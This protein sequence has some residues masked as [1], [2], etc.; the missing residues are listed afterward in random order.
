MPLW[1]VQASIPQMTP[2]HLLPP[3]FVNWTLVQRE[4]QHKPDKVP[5]GPDGRAIDHTDPANWMSYDQAVAVGLPV[6][7]VLT[8]NDPFVFIDLD[9]CRDP[10]SGAWTPEAQQILSMFPGALMEIS[11]SGRG[12]HII[13]T[14]EQRVMEGKRKKWEGDKEVYAWGRFVALTGYGLQGDPRVDLTAPLSVW[15]PNKPD[16]ATYGIPETGPVPE[17]SGETDDLALV[18]HALSARGG[19]GVQF[20]QHAS[21]RD[22]WTGNVASLARFYPSYNQVDPFD[23][24]AADAALVMHLGF[25]TGKDMARTERLWRA[26]PLTQG[27]RKL[28]RADYVHQTIM[29]GLQKVRNVYQRPTASSAALRSAIAGRLVAVGTHHD[30]A[31]AYVGTHRERFLYNS[32]RAVWLEWSGQRW[33][34]LPDGAVLSDIRQFCS[35]TSGGQDRRTLSLGFWQAVEVTCQIDPAFAKS[36]DQFDRDNYLLNTP[37]G[38]IDLRTGDRHAHDPAD[39]ITAMTAADP[40][41]GAGTVWARFLS[42]V[43]CGDANLARDLQVALGASLSGAVEDH[44]F[45]Y[46]TGSGRNGKSALVEAVAHALGDYARAVPAET[47]VA[48]RNDPHPTGLTT[49]VG[50]RLAYAN[51]VPAGRYFNE[52]LLKSVTGDR[53]I[54]ARY[55]RGDYFSFDRTFKLFLIGNDLPQ[56]RASDVAMQRR[57]RIFCLNADFSGRE[58]PTLPDRLRDDAG[59]ILQWLIEGHRLWFTAG[60]SFKPSAAVSAVSADYFAAQSTPDMW[61]SE[62][63]EIV[64]DDG[65]S[66]TGWPSSRDAYLN[67]RAW[68]SGR[69]EEPISET[70]FGL[71]LRGKAGVSIVKA[72]AMRC[73]GLTLKI[74]QIPGILSFKPRI[75]PEAGG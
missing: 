9:N 39:M 24:S 15:V 17:W 52:T 49:L 45:G 14:C 29:T 51:E 64:P 36:H 46:V 55:M 50:A 60:R 25:W 6:A 37:S 27:R 2:F 41:T 61:L 5:V 70:R 32:T 47:F 72:S 23:R 42:E 33:K 68:K 44:W 58:D 53:Q 57:L 10:M 11:Q 48:S 67:Y 34:P 71:W 56:I 63:A 22:L 26:A 19:I 62:C 3:Q 8:E 12:A 35:A 30:M 65:R 13:G 40:V 43:T 20:G 7:F 59:A 31:L 38:T 54:S 73:K 28:D 4:G 74:P 21:F 18:Q 66:A 16:L 75:L 69:G 1:Q